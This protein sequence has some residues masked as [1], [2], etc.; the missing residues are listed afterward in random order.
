MSDA[1]GLNIRID[2]PKAVYLMQRFLGLE[3]SLGIIAGE[4]GTCR[5]QLSLRLKEL[6]PTMSIDEGWIID[7]LNLRLRKNVLESLEIVKEDVND[8]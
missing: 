6:Y 4:L 1:N 7:C 5:V 3:Q 8:D 2:D